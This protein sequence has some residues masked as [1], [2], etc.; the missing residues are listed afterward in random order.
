MQTKYDAFPKS[1]GLARLKKSFTS[2]A[3]FLP[4]GAH[5]DLTNV[6]GKILRSNHKCYM[7]HSKLNGK[8]ANGKCRNRAAECKLQP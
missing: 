1:F 2:P 7:L 4:I 8:I 6:P 5:A 3:P